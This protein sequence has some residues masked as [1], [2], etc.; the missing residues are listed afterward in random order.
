[1]TGDSDVE[2]MLALQRGDLRAFDLLYARWQ[3]P[4]H[5]FVSRMLGRPGAEDVVQEVFVRVYRARERYKPLAS[6]R[7]WLFRIAAHLCSN[8]RRR[9]SARLEVVSTAPVELASPAS[10]DPGRQAE[11]RQLQHAV[12]R[13]LEVL[14][15]RQRAAV[16]LARYEGCSMAEIA[17]ILE[18]SPGAAKL[19]LHRAREQLRRELAP[20][21]P[22][23]GED[24]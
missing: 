19:L 3:L 21:L 17:E 1:V 9:A 15:E 12:D 10:D 24:P 8:E 20:F 5:R 23:S 22:G 7:A 2:T 6:F 16:L 4:V 13:A 14:P 18:I 11:G